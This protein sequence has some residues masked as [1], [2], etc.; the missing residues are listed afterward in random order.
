[1]VRYGDISRFKVMGI[2]FDTS[3]L[4]EAVSSH[5][6]LSLMEELYGDL[7]FYIPKSVVRE[8]EN[9]ASGRGV[10][11]KRAKLV[12]KYIG[13]SSRFK[14]I[15]SKSDVVDDDLLILACEGVFIVATGDRRL[16]KRLGKSGVRIIYLKDDYPH[17]V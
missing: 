3:F 15:D 5:G 14:I 4:L 11:A 9:L 2:L 16:R 17:I 8:L 10:K 12:L 7:P 6:S 13:E 1:M